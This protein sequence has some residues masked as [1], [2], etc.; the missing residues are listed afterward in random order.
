ML[1]HGKLQQAARQ[2]HPNTF[3]IIT[4]APLSYLLIVDKD[5]EFEKITASDMQNGMTVC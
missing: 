2:R 1:I 5:I 4:V 3:Q